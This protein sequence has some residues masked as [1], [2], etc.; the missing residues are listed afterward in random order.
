MGV[1][2]DVREALIRTGAFMLRVVRSSDWIAVRSNQHVPL[3]QHETVLRPLLARA[4]EAWVYELKEDSQVFHAAADILVRQSGKYRIDLSGEPI[5][6][7]ELL[8]N[9][10][11][12]QRGS[13]ALVFTDSR[14]PGSEI[15]PH[16]QKAFVIGNSTVPHSAAAIRLARGKVN[17]GYICSLLSRTNGFE[18]L[19]VYAPP[20]A[21]ESMLAEAQS[22]V[23]ERALYNQGAA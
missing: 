13:I 3:P 19:S 17:Q 2:P 5:R 20:S 6:G 15:Y 22:M 9:A 7:H 14:F 12:G 1:A 11:G 23:V 16:C 4:A 18:W 8:W 10:S 21:I